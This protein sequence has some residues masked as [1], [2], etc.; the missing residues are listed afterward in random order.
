MPSGMLGTFLSLVD[1][2]PLF[3]NTGWGQSANLAFLEKHMGASF[4]KRHQPWRA[5]VNPEDVHSGDF[6]AVS[7]IRGRWGGFE[8]LEKWV[9]G[10]FAGHTS[11]CLKDEKGNLWVG[12]SGHENE[13]VCC[14]L[15][16]PIFCYVWFLCFMIFIKTNANDAHMFYIISNPLD[17][18][19][20]MF[21]VKSHPGKEIL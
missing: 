4:E 7:K 20:V 12:E 15:L 3:S 17:C 18:Q 2:L 5:T 9:T 21:A 14:I 8:T 10:A 11:V 19:I 6:L 1:V 13:K 16:V